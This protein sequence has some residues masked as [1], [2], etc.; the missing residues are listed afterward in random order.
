MQLIAFIR[1]L[2]FNLRYLPLRQAVHLPVWITGNFRTVQLSRGQLV[3]HRPLRKSVIL[4]AGGSPGLPAFHGGLYLAP[5]SRLVLRGFTVVGEGSVLRCDAGARLE[6]GENF[7]CNKNCFLRS[8]NVIRFGDECLLGWNVQINTTDGHPIRRNGV[9]GPVS[10]PVEVGRRVWITANTILTK[11]VSIAEGCVV[12]QGAVVTK[13][14]DTPRALVGGVPA[15]VIAT[16]IDW[17]K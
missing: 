16:D 15:R 9:A 1:S 14:V 12:A 5:G 10:A 11:G 4:G 6:L 3:L 2:C 13:S 8:A 7:Y 17:E